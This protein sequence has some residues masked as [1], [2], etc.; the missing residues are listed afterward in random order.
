MTAPIIDKS[1]ALCTQKDSAGAGL[2]ISYALACADRHM[3]PCTTSINLWTE[4]VQDGLISFP[5]RSQASLSPSILPKVVSLVLLLEDEGES[6]HDHARQFAS[7]LL[8]RLPN[9]VAAR[10]SYPMESRATLVPLL[11]LKHLDFDMSNLDILEGMSFSALVPKLESAAISYSLEEGVVSSLDFSGC[12]HL[13]RLAM[14]NLAVRCLS[15][16]PQCRLNVSMLN[17]NT[18][19]YK[20]TNMAQQALTRVKEI[21]LDDDELSAPEGLLARVCLPELEVIRCG[22]PDA[23]WIEQS[24]KLDTLMHCSRHSRNVPAL[25]SI[26][27]GDHRRSANRSAVKVCIP[28]CLA[29]VHEIMLATDRSVELV[30]DSACSAGESLN[31]F[32]VVA[33]EIR[34]D[35]A[36]LLGM[37]DA[38][39]RR[40]LT[41][42]MAQAG[43]EHEH[44]PSQCM[45]VRAVSAPQ[46]SYDHLVQRVNKRIGFW[47][48]HQG[49]AQCGACHWCLREIGVLH[50]A[51]SF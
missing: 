42:S 40:G 33:S 51:P 26:L 49:C 19:I 16:P 32:C 47:A 2:K 36:A 1:W 8:Q 9:L 15:L 34:V 41:L 27:S 20:D 22:W 23:H 14:A 17:S 5:G 18:S 29:G 24:N 25:K 7:S 13:V 39:V 31:T 12:Q 48:R 50:W 6:D 45:Y 4:A 3:G 44:A 46:L 11:K 21:D 35:V 37:T 28:A 38:L 30:F 43:Q 10:I